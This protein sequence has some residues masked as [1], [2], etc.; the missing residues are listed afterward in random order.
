MANKAII[1]GKV[2]C[3][4]DMTEADRGKPMYCAGKNASGQS[5]L[6][7]MVLVCTEGRYSFRA[8]HPGGHILGCPYDKAS[9]ESGG[10][11]FTHLDAS[12]A[13]GTLD[14]LFL[15]FGTE[16]EKREKAETAVDVADT[17]EK[18]HEAGSR[19]LRTGATLPRNVTQLAELLMT[20]SEDSAYDGIPV[21]WILP[22]EAG[23][24]P[25]SYLAG[26]GGYSIF[27]CS[28]CNPSYSGCENLVPNM[29]IMLRE[30][31]SVHLQTGKP[32][33]GQ[34]KRNTYFILPKL[35]AAARDLVF[36]EKAKVFVVFSRWKRVPGRHNVY[37][38]D[39]S[40]TIT[41]KSLRVYH[42]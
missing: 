5:C 25:E 27:F 32:V 36:D 29:G 28:R 37:M 18:P 23:D 21:K 1:D 17:K 35:T 16:A 4:R 24:L 19:A 22:D 14:S 31:P 7:E 3:A 39:R 11:S 34:A 26:E 9:K 42:P 40:V 6:A 15:R 2:V 12:G 30:K 41:K 10:K 13:K 38:A 20:L 8:K 33:P